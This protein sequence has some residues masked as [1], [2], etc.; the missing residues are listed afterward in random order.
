MKDLHEQNYYELLDITTDANQEAIVTAYNKARLTYGNSSPALYSLFNKEEAEELLK[1][2]DEA[3]SVLSNQFKRREYDEKYFSK[4]KTEER[5][6]EPKRKVENTCSALQAR[7]S[8][9]C[10]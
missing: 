7:T 1:L 9:R 4:P 10:D 5:S 2:I 8:V 6:A 3:Y